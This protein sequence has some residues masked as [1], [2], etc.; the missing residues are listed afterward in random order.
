MS[1]SNRS[2]ESDEDIQNILTDLDGILSSLNEPGPAVPA[3]P[4]LAEQLAAEVDAAQKAHA[5]EE[6]EKAAAEKAAA[7]AKAAEEKAAAEKA[8]AEAKAAQEKAAAEKAAAEA[9][10]AQEKAAAE[11]AAAEA[12]AAEEKAA[13]EKAAAEAKGQATTEVTGQAAEPE[14]KPTEQPTKSAPPPASSG[15]PAQGGPA[16]LAPF[17]GFAVEEIPKKVPLEQVRRIAFLFSEPHGSKYKKVTKFIFDVAQKVSK[18]PLYVHVPLVAVVIPA[19]AVTEVR[20][21]VIKSGAV[22]AIG[23][24]DGL[25]D[26]YIRKLDDAFDEEDVFLRIIKPEE[27]GKRVSAIDLVVDMMLLKAG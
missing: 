1:E 14:S 11:K 6:E 7:E 27:V 12:K 13:A 26:E 16:T 20:E 22:G 9:K 18:K 25:P 24:L 4:K 19:I 2:G 21:A 15:A 17:T 23:L 5:L 8:A 10:A 3:G